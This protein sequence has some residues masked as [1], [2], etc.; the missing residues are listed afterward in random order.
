A[1]DDLLTLLADPPT[2]ATGDPDAVPNP[3]VEPITSPGDLWAIGRH[4]LL[5]GDATS[6]V[7]VARVLGGTPADLLLTDP[8]YN[9]AY[10]GGTADRLTIA[11]DDL[12]PNDFQQFLAAALSA[13]AAHL[14]PGGGF[15][16]WHA[17][18][19][20]LPVRMAAAAAGLR[21]RQCLV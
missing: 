5:C 16:V 3:P 10:E 4:R 2:E 8:P 9:V 12:T 13:A 20:G 19:F 15:Y 14:R 6:A 1:E 21:V 7:D 17:D 18:T 11:N